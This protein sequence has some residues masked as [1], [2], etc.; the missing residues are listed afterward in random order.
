MCIRD[1]Q[2]E[3]STKKS[4]EPSKEFLELIGQWFINSP[5]LQRIDNII[6]LYEVAQNEMISEYVSFNKFEVL[7]N[8][9]FS[10]SGKKLS[11][12]KNGLI[13]IELPNNKD[14]N[15]YRLS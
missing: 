10:D 2:K 15:I 4:K 12:K 7:A 3:Q 14:S 8:K 13:E 9:Y 5:Q 1:R 6:S 11:I